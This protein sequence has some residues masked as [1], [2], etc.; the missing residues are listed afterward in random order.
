VSPSETIVARPYQR[1]WSLALLRSRRPG[2]TPETYFSASAIL[3]ARLMRIRLVLRAVKRRAGRGPGRLRSPRGPRLGSAWPPARGTSSAGLRR[4]RTP[5][6]V[7]PSRSAVPGL[8]SRMRPPRVRAAVTHRHRRRP[9]VPEI[10]DPR[11]AA[12]RQGAVRRGVRPG[13]EAPAIGHAP[14]GEAR[15]VVR[16]LAP[17]NT[18]CAT[19]R[20]PAAALP[21]AAVAPPRA[22]CRAPPRPPGRTVRS[23]RARRPRKPSTCPNASS[24][25]PPAVTALSDDAAARPW[26]APRSRAERGLCGRRL[27]P[28]TAGEEASRPYVAAD[29]QRRDL[30]R[31][32]SDGRPPHLP[33][34]PSKH[35]PRSDRPPR[36]RPA[37]LRATDQTAGPVAWLAAAAL[38]GPSTR[39]PQ[40]NPDR[41]WCTG[42]PVDGS[43][44]G[45][46]TGVGS[47]SAERRSWGR[48]TL[49]FGTHIRCHQARVAPARPGGVRPRPGRCR[50]GR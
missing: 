36:T 38:S 1:P 8:T 46:S 16:G 39:P 22:L 23:K 34:A 35:R 14:A 42:R 5:L 33:Q 2:R 30:L 32:S 40:T 4:T 10:P 41:R 11:G 19:H 3:V 31:T 48:S 13:V 15:R 25:V 50:R 17:L 49:P 12:E 9:P 45:T 7:I 27:G 37:A 6:S 21:P 24:S 47:S 20:K 29:L 28:A 44:I 43:N 18:P 26:F